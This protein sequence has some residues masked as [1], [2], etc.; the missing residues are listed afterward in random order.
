M[1]GLNAGPGWT[2]WVDGPAADQSKQMIGTGFGTLKIE[3]Q[4]TIL[5]RCA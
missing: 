2:S 4:D 1:R 5:M 3:F